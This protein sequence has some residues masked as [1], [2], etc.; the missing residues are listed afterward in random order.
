VQRWLRDSGIVLASQGGALLATTALAVL[1]ARALGPHD[2]GIFA[3]FYGVS[4]ALAR[5]IDIGITTWLLRELAAIVAR[6]DQKEGR[7]QASGV[8]SPALA[9]MATLLLVFLIA[10]VAI[11]AILSVQ[12]RLS[13][14]LIGLMAYTGLITCAD[15]LD[16]I[17]R[18]HRRLGVV[19]AMTVGEK[20]TLL[21]TVAVSLVLHLGMPG[22]ALSYVISGTARVTVDLW[23]ISARSLAG[24]CRVRLAEMRRIARAA[25][26][27]GFGSSAPSGVVRLD[28]FAIGLLSAT[29]A[30]FYSVADRFVSVLA[31]IPVSGATALY[32][33]LAQ[34]RNRQ[35][36]TLQ[37]TLLLAAIGLVLALIAIV[38]AGP[39]I[40]LLFGSRYAGAVPATHVLLLG[41]PLLFAFTALM[42]GLFAQGLERPVLWVTLPNMLLGTGFVITGQLV[43]GTVGACA[44]CVLRYLVTTVGLTVLSRTRLRSRG[45]DAGADS[46]GSGPTEPML[47]ILP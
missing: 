30:G 17:F 45:R 29:S 11:T 13:V 5:L 12:L 34:H 33:I 44:G 38:L 3:G 39:L 24:R 43:D 37:V 2:Y 15:A 42:A 35:R 40:R 1:V 16:T 10:T 18:A 22:I 20:L 28:V 36:A 41:T 47:E 8:M 46:E 6:G 9:V 4:I 27:L 14:A 21:A 7:E 32:P 25:L 31:V 26:P 23:L 19:F